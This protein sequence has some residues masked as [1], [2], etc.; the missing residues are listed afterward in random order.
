[1][2]LQTSPAV[3]KALS[4]AKPALGAAPVPRGSPS[5]K[6]TKHRGSHAPGAAMG[7]S[8][9]PLL[10]AA[11][12]QRRGINDDYD[13]ASVPGYSAA[14]A[15]GGR[16]R[17]ADAGFSAPSAASLQA[18]LLSET[19]ARGAAQA[20]ASQAQEALLAEQRAHQATRRQL[21]V[22]P[23]CLAFHHALCS[24]PASLGDE[25]AGC[26][27]AV[28]A[29]HQ[30][31]ETSANVDLVVMRPSFQ[32]VCRT[33]CRSTFGEPLQLPPVGSLGSA[34]LPCTHACPVLI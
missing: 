26:H 1:M 11:A 4:P 32:P 5:K 31:L 34:Y 28:L 12:A 30:R 9:N 27:T 14:A 8:I 23:H 15:A 7:Q 2:Q 16:A 19:Q 13:T 10:E 6:A 17:V 18:Q 22:R 33:A 24:C 20:A 21:Q 3:G 25:G 29:A